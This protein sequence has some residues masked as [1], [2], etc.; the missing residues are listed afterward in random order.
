MQVVV[1]YPRFGGRNKKQRAQREAVADFV[2]TSRC[3][4]NSE[5]VETEPGLPMLRKAIEKCRRTGDSLVIGKMGFLI[6]SLAVL[7]MLRDGNVPFFVL[8][9]QQLNPATLQVY[10]VH[11]EEA[12]TERS[13]KIKDGIKKARKAGQKFGSA[14]RGHWN[15][16]NRHLRDWEKANEVSVKLRAQRVAEAY[17]PI[18]PMMDAMRKSGK[19]YDE[20]ATALNDAGHLTAAGTPF[21]APTVFKILKRHGGKNG[22]R[23]KGVGRAAHFAAAER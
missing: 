17:A 5:F 6:R 9:D 13:L 20:I 12:W 7:R 23:G 3:T 16:T 19:T 21:I 8:D 10:L 15:K 18:L 14:Q 2:K 11:A 4:V 22:A 1:Y